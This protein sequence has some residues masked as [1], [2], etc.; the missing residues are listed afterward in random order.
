MSLVDSHENRDR[1]SQR[2]AVGRVADQFDQRGMVCAVYG[3]GV[4]RA[5]M[6]VWRGLGGREGA[7]GT[8][9]SSPTAG[10]LSPKASGSPQGS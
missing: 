4:D 2:L 10:G 6:D 9:E 5:W 8:L 1:L 3:E 7:L